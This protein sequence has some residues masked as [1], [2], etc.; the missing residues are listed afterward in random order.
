VVGV[1]R[2]AREGTRDMREYKHQMITWCLYS[3]VPLVP[4]P[5]EGR[6]PPTAHRL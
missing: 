3:C 1:S 5:A 2:F 4:A 6:R